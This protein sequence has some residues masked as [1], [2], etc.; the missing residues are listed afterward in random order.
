PIAVVRPN[1]SD[2]SKPLIYH[3]YADHLNTPRAIYD[4][5]NKRLTWR[6]ESE[7]FGNTLPDQDAD[8]NGNQFV[9]NL[10]FPGQQWDNGIKL[11]H[12]GYRTYNPG[13]RR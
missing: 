12:N 1:S 9:Y 4:A 8:K 2:P 7:A 5:F 13:G 11:S 3:V 10:C 6:W